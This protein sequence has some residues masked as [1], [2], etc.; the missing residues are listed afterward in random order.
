MS[1]QIGRGIWVQ[2][3]AM[4]LAIV[5]VAFLAVGWWPLAVLTGAATAVAAFSVRRAV[6]AERTDEALAARDQ[7]DREHGAQNQH[8]EDSSS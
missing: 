1:S 7:Y 3:T 4:G 5:T 2:L 6:V 8:D